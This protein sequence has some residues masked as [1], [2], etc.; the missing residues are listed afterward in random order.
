[1]KLISDQKTYR[2]LKRGT[3][4]SGRIKQVQKISLSNLILAVKKN[5]GG[6]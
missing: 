2:K 1:M 6:I 3:V 5:S 4:W